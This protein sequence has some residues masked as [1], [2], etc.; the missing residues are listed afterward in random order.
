MFLSAWSAELKK[1]AIIC[2]Y[3]ALL[4]VVLLAGMDLGKVR[5]LPFVGRRGERSIGIFTGKDP[6]VLSAPKGV[7]QPVLTAAD[8]NDRNAHYIADPFL[9]RYKDQ[10]HMFFEV[11][12][13]GDGHCVIATASS[14]DGFRWTYGKVV[15]DEPF[16]ISYPYVFESD[17]A[18]Y[19]VCETALSYA[20][21]LY[22][23]VDFPYEWKLDAKILEGI[24]LD[25][26]IFRYKGHWW[27]FTN[28]KIGEMSAFW[29]D[30][31]KGTWRPHRRNPVVR[32]DETA[33]RPGGRV[34]EWNG[35]LIRYSQD[36]E[37]RYFKAVRAIE[38]TELTDSTYTEHPLQPDP[39]IGPT[40]KGWNTTGMHQCDVHP[41]GD[42]TWIACV[43]GMQDLIR[44]GWQY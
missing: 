21:R 22:K 26:S 13:A 18:V 25:P 15:I 17:S 33:S 43:D 6:L 2:A 9:I 28:T 12:Q 44:F 40:G 41:Y 29:A 38:V 34:I 16:T 11:K 23:A 35:R 27:I 10:W 37:G 24:H 42:G 4:I 5:G 19:M 14:D 31:L 7:S 8:V 30:S 36:V 1:I 32:N 20:V 39:V 3:I